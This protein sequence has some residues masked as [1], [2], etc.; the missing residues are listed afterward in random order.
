MEMWLYQ[1]PVYAPADLT[2]CE[3]LALTALD[4]GTFTS[5]TNTTPSRFPQGGTV[6]VAA[7]VADD[8]HDASISDDGSAVAFVSTRDLVP[9]GN[10]FPTNDNDEIFVFRQGG[11]ITQITRTARGPISDPI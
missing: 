9:G 11:S 10:S 3:D 2:T 7:S 1:I 5:L 4:G 8:N 6:L